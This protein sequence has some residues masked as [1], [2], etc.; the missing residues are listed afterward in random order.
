MDRIEGNGRCQG[1][2][3]VDRKNNTVSPMAFAA[4][5]FMHITFF[6]CKSECPVLFI[7]D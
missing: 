2:E 4:M 1:A 7:Q 3:D 6:F 5:R